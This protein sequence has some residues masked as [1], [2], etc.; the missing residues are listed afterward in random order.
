MRLITQIGQIIALILLIGYIVY[1]FTLSDIVSIIQIYIIF[2][3]GGILIAFSVIFIPYKK[4]EDDV[5][6][7]TV[8]NNIRTYVIEYTP[9]DINLEPFEVEYDN[10]YDKSDSMQLL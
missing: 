5:E 7:E 3:V 2:I 4:V 9:V 8:E 1:L 6:L 10:T